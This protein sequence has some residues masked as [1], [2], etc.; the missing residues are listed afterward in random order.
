MQVGW[1]GVKFSGKKRYECVR[2]N[3]ISVTYEGVG[4]GPIS[5][6]KALR[7]KN[8]PLVEPHAGENN[9]YGFVWSETDAAAS[10]FLSM[11]NIGRGGGVKKYSKHCFYQFTTLWDDP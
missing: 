11:C 7:N 8:G 10:H 4:G 1:R 9:N 5:R 6:T 2:F 3:V